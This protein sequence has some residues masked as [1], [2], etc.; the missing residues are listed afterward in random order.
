MSLLSAEFFS[1]VKKYP[2]E[3]L[4][5]FFGND[6]GVTMF[7]EAES[8]FNFLTDNI[9]ANTMEPLDSEMFDQPEQKLRARKN[10][11]DI[12]KQI[13]KLVRI[14]Q[15]NKALMD[16]AEKEIKVPGKQASSGNDI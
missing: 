3:E 12:K 11:R 8:E 4:K 10:A 15:S 6:A 7:L 14:F 2:K 1:E 13:L 5:Q 9:I 16:R